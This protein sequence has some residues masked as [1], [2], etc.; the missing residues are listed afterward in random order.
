MPFL[1]PARIKVFGILHIVFAG[2]GFLSA[3]WN[4]A[5]LYFKEPLQN[6][7]SLGGP[8]MA[9]NPVEEMQEAM[10]RVTEFYT[11]ASIVIGVLL[12]ALMLVAGI[13]LVRH[14]RSALRWSNAYAW[15]SIGIKLASLAYCM[16]VL[17]PVVNAELDKLVAGSAGGSSPEQVLIRYLVSAVFVI[18]PLVSCVYPVLT[19][20]MLNKP[21]VR[22]AL[23]IKNA[24]D[25]IL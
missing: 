8:R 1:P 22:A 13:A 20:V 25:E 18:L 19:L 3:L 11:S 10:L 12:S 4:L 6:F 2:I 23:G 14:H 15:S 9:R 24:S 16:I 21:A 7:A 5:K 17:L